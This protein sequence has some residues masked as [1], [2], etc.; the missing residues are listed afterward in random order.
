MKPTIFNEIVEGH[1]D[2]IDKL[3]KLGLDKPCNFVLINIE[4]Q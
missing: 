2:N 1:K 3:F 4:S